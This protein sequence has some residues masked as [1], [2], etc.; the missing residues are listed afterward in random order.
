MRELSPVPV[1]L[2]RR[3]MSEERRG[4]HFSRASD[5]YNDGSVP[6]RNNSTEVSHVPQHMDFT[7]LGED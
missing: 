2:S 5:N 7:L 6:R 3:R 1:I 4:R